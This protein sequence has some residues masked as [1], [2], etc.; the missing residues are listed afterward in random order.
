MGSEMCIRDRS[1]VL[2]HELMTTEFEAEI[3]RNGDYG[4]AFNWILSVR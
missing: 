3:D 1:K 2:G 4:F